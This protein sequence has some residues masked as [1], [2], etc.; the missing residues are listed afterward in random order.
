MQTIDR[1]IHP[2]S[3]LSAS[4]GS[5]KTHQLVLEYLSILL[6]DA[7]FKRKYKSLVAMTFTNKAAR[8]MK[9]RIAEVIGE[10]EARNI[11]MGTFHSVFSR[12]L[13]KEHEKL[14][15][16]SNFTIY[17]TADTKSLIKTI[18]KDPF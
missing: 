3:V 2:L 13:R 8:E 16:P 12:I 15:Y 17:D 7:Q 11:W 1:N 10:G 5:G 9:N 14:N 6:K 4:A 18:I